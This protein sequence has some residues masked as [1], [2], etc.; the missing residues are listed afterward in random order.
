MSATH[1]S[2]VKAIAILV[3]MILT[4]LSAADLTQYSGPGVI[5]SNGNSRTVDGWTVPGNATILDGWLNIESGNFPNLGNGSGWDGSTANA[6]FTSGTYV[7]STSTHFDEILSLDTNGSYGNIDEFNEAPVLS[8][9]SGVTSGG[10]GAIWEP[11]YLNYSGTP[12]SGGGNTVGNGTIPASPTEGNIVVGTNPNGGVPPGTDAW[13]YRVF[14]PTPTTIPTPIA[15]FT[16][17]FDH[18]Y[19]I[20]TPN[21]INGDMDGVWVEYRLDNGS[22]TWIAPVSGYNNTISP[23]ATV[24]AG[25]NQSANGT[26]GFPVWAKTAYSGWEHSVFEL[27]NLT[28]INNATQINFRFRIWTHQNSTVRPGW[29]ID[30]ITLQNIG[31]GTGYW[32][33]GCYV[34][35]GT[36]GYSNNAVGVLQLTQPMNLSGVTGNPIL[37]THLEWDLEG[38]GWDNFCVELSLNNNTWVDISS[39]NNA[40]TTACRSRTGAIPGSGYT[41]GGTT[42]GDETN[43]LLDLDLAIPAAFQNQSTVYLRYRVDTDSSVTNG[44]TLDGQEGLTLDRIQVLSSATNNSTSY[45]DD[46]L[47]NSGTAF[48]YTINAID[49]WAYVIIGAGGLHEHYGFEDSPT[50]PPGGGNVVDAGTGDIWEYGQLPA[51]GTVG[52]TSWSTGNYGFAIDLDDDYDGNSITHLYSPGYMIP[53]GASARLSFD[54]WRHSE[55]NWDGGAVFIK[56]NN[57]TWQHFDPVLANGSSWYDGSITFGT[58]ILSNLDVFDGRQFTGTVPWETTTAD[59]SNYSGSYVEFRFSFACDSIINDAGWYIDDVG[60]EVDFFENEGSWIS[61]TITLDELGDGFVDISA[62]TP[63]GTWVTGTITDSAGN[64][65][66]GYDNLSFP[67]SLAGIDRDTY[68]T[69]KIQINMGTNDP[70][71]SP[72]VTDIHYGAVRYFAGLDAQNGWNIDGSLTQV[73]GNWTN[74]TGTPLTI[75]SDFITSTAPMQYVNTTGVGTGVTVQLLDSKGTIIGNS[76]LN[77]MISFQ[78]PEPGYGIQFT[79]A[80]SGEL[81]SAIAFGNIGQ[82]TL[83]PQIDVTDDGTIDWTFPT[84][85]NFGH[86]GWQSYIHLIESTQT[87]TGT[88][89]ASITSTSTGS[90]IEVLIPDDATVNSGMITFLP[91]TTTTSSLAMSVAGVQSLPHNSGLSSL[92]NAPFDATMIAGINSLTT[93]YNDPLTGRVWKIVDI[94]FS[95]SINQNIDIMSISIGYDITENLTGLGQ[96]MFD[97]HAAQLTNSVPASIDIPLTFVA[98]AGAVG[99]EGGIIH[100]LMITN[101]PFSAPATMY[102]DGEIYEIVTRHHHLIDNN[103]IGEVM[104]I[105]TA[106]DGE[107]IS[108]QVDDL[109]NGGTFVSNGSTMATLLPSSS[110]ILSSG[111]WVITWQFEITWFWDDVDQIDW[112]SRALNLTGEGLAPAFAMSGGPGRNAIENDLQ[113][114]FFEVRDEFDRIITV[115]PNQDFYAAG[116]SDITITGTVRFQDNANLRP[117]S[118]AYSV[119]INYSGTEYPANS[120]DNGSYSLTLT[121]PTDVALT[122][123]T[124]RIVRVGPASGAFGGDDVSNP[125]ATIAVITDIENPDSDIFQVL[126][127]NGLLDANGHVWDPFQSLTLHLTVTDVQALG[128]DVVL[129]YWRQGV[130]DQNTDGIADESEYQTMSRPISLPGRA[131][132]QQ[133]QF[134][135]IDVSSLPANG[136]LSLYIS[137]TDWAGLSFNNS[138]A[139]GIDNDKATMVIGIDEDTIL[140]ENSLML[141]TNNDHLLVGQNHQISMIIEDEN[142]IH[143]IDEVIIYLTGQQ[144]SPAGVIHID[145]R[146]ATA[147]APMGSFVTPGTVTME[148]LDETSSRLTLDF[149]LNWDFPTS[150]NGNWLMP[151]IHIID[152]TQTV[153]NVNNIGALRWK[154][155]NQ[156]TVEIDQLHDLTEPLSASGQSTLFLGKGDIFA[157]TGTVIYA[158]SG[159]PI[160]EIPENMQLYAAMVANG[161]TSDVVY[162]LSEAYFNTTLSVPI[163]YPSTNALPVTIDVLNIPG[164]ATSLTN[165]NISLTIDSTPPVAEFPPGIMNSIETDRLSTINVRINV[166]EAGGMADDGVVMHWVYRRGGL[167]LPGSDGSAT[168]EMDSVLGDVWIY[169]SIVDM[170]PASHI[171]LQEGDQVAVWLVGSDLAGNEL[172]GEGTANSPRAPQL[173]IR[174]FQPVISKVEFDDINPTMGAMVYIQ[175][176]IRNNGTTMG[177][178]NVTLVEELDDGSL[179]IYESHNISDLGPQQKRIVAFSWEAWDTGKPDLYLMWNEDEASLSLLEPQIDVKKVETE[180]GIFGAGANMGLI[181][182]VLAILVSGVVIAIVAVMMRSRDEWDDEEEWEGAEEYAEKMLGQQ[183]AAPVTSQPASVPQDAPLPEQAPPK[184]PEVSDADW[185]VVAKEQIPDW[186]DEALLGYKENGWTIEQLMDWKANNP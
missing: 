45:F 9:A 145:P 12:A 34:A 150:F 92:T 21:N 76:G 149:V 62:L 136:F 113:I 43:A 39:T 44:G 176:T 69:A 35:T 72:L 2:Q 93:T 82:P 22:W 38:S 118:N 185:L 166:V 179:Q 56:A 31:G 57:G 52:P 24:P 123:L 84:A 1:K 81:E 8:L 151:G 77:N 30:N 124:P 112:M 60:V 117:L 155:D 139:A 91:A 85:P 158:G 18:W 5:G 100:E 71:I 177:S 101:L 147:F 98:D 116:G 114:D 94:D 67:I 32:H 135:G 159:A 132:E 160:V 186:S 108:W 68:P 141:N 59:L 25:T 23:S 6:N 171:V 99:L 146:E 103:Q 88:T 64:A 16:F 36:C 165:M 169:S 89:T 138:G 167:N 70:F 78:N 55:A 15:N 153:A 104:L 174:V 115:D 95:S 26:H 120:H 20:N 42:Y 79:I 128:E 41:I 61:P 53:L 90:G 157:I 178:V 19:H 7:D 13:L 75:T 96:Q 50:M 110:A 125:Q 131:N 73:N 54:Q 143:T 11:T 172:F 107:L 83:N 133:I 10:T 40:T 122:T 97:Y 184:P 182:G 127:T 51:A 109:A 80:P 66:D 181:L 102:P 86:Y 137:G 33:H 175:T 142:G 58:H 180:G 106:S 154:L 126:T 87:N 173:I 162:D 130:D 74:P 129:H 164:Q 121:L 111:D 183:A 46:Q 3:L 161:V 134:N 170:T 4:P 168:L 14:R 49:D 144:S 48:H 119:A 65:F 140:L 148:T 152:D 156:L 105:G 47:S 37:R 163:G 28:G 29:F 17:E 63:N 27:D